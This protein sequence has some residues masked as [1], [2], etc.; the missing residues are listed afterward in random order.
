MTTEHL[1]PPI[2]S[3]RREVFSFGIVTTLGIASLGVLSHVSPEEPGNYPTCPFLAMTGYYCPGCG[4]LRAV[5]ALTQG[6]VVTAWERNPLAIALL[7]FV[8]LSWLA[9][10]LRILGLT[11]WSPTR[12]NTAWIWGL[13]ALVLVYWLARNI[14][15][16][17]WLSPL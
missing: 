15:G 16:C 2:K 5:H 3:R 11:S 6:D 17:T 13:L 7:P 10:G 1:T 4:S 12:I 9:W 8:M 14:P